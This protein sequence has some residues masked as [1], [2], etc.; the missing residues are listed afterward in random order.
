MLHAINV[1]IHRTP[2]SRRLSLRLGLLGQAPRDSPSTI[3]PVP[4]VIGLVDPRPSRRAGERALHP[5]AA[6]DSPTL[7]LVLRQ[8]PGRSRVHPLVA[9][10]W[11]ESLEPVAKA[12]GPLAYL[13]PVREA[14]QCV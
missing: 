4:R 7:N 6:P 11:R 5:E 8:T 10:L 3:W 2:V 12:R 14:A 13:I 9:G 1:N